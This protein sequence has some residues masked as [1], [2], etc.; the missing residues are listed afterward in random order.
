MLIACISDL[1]NLVNGLFNT[2]PMDQS[3]IEKDNKDDNINDLKN[4]IAPLR[5]SFNFSIKKKSIKSV[6][7]DNFSKI[8]TCPL[9][10]RQNTLFE[11]NILKILRKKKTINTYMCVANK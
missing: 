9:K 1:V 2:D 10:W 7:A 11:V 5:E 8:N 4:V 6:V 3:A